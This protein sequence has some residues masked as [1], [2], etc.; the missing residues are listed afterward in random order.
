MITRGPTTWA[1]TPWIKW[2]CGLRFNLDVGLVNYPFETRDSLEH[3]FL[4]PL[5]QQAAGNNHPHHFRRAFIDFG[6]LG[7]PIE[8]LDLGPLNVADSTMDLHRTVCLTGS[9]FGGEQLRHR[10]L[11]AVRRVL[12]IAPGAVIGQISGNLY[13]DRHVGEHPLDRLELANRLAELD[14]LFLGLRSNFYTADCMPGFLTPSCE[15]DF[16][17]TPHV[18]PGSKKIGRPPSETLNR[19]QV[20]AGVNVT[21]IPLSYFNSSRAMTRR[22]ISLVPS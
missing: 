1:R 19:R 3:S 12:M 22:C 21:A 6:Y 11:T 2:A 15:A 5:A 10:S 13:F 8:P 20:T 14:S 18:I 17:S 4:F 7:V 9:R 16:M